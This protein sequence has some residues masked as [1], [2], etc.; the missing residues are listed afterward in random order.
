MPMTLLTPVPL[1]IVVDNVINARPLEGLL[2][3]VL[4]QALEQSPG[5]MLVTAIGLLV[6]V[7]LIQQIE[8]FGSW[9]L[10]LYTGERMV[11]D[12][13]IRLFR[14]A[15]RLSLQYHDQA[16][17]SDTLYRI[18][19]D[20]PAMQYLIVQGLIPAITS[21]L[22]VVAILCVTAYIDLWLAFVAITIVPVLLG[23]TELYRRRVRLGWATVKE[24]ES[25]AMSVV[26]EVLGAV[27]VVKAFGQEKREEYRFSTHANR[28]LWTQIGVVL[29]EARFGI[30]VAV[31]VACGTG[32]V[33]YIGARHV[34]AGLLSLGDLLV[35]MA[36]L[37]ML[38][39]PLETLS[40]KAASLQAS[41][42]SA[43]RAYRLFD[44]Q[45]EVPETTTPQPLKRAR[46]HIEF[47]DVSYAY[48][49]RQPVLHNLT[50]QVT[51]GTS[52]G[53]AGPTG[54]GKTT[55]IGLLFRF[56]DPTEGHIKLDGTDIRDFRLTDLRNQFAIV[57]QEPVLFAA[58][59]AENIAYG[60]PEASPEEI[61]AAAV[62]ANAHEFIEQLPEGYQ[63]VV[64][65][66]GAGISGGQRQRISLARAFLKDAPILVLDEP[67]SS[68]D[69]LSESLI[70]EAMRRLMQGR[71][72]LM[73]SHRSTTLEASDLR[74]QLEHGCIVSL[75]RRD[76]HAI[77]T[78]NEPLRPTR[79]TQ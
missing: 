62:A 65:Q 21:V 70:M 59:I 50:F 54:A 12:F 72:T 45:E 25:S 46:G 74:L 55:L 22:T 77:S 44:E 2:A 27:R 43:E 68:V 28:S 51:P 19:H 1:K 49:H 11:L 23:L 64:G 42:A 18:E 56:F 4:P 9:I 5:M 73:I 35:V 63:T 33:L 52:V 7:T 16:G 58:T 78:S 41:L 39:K 53:I 69:V 20:A 26:Q 60:R 67:T 14:H 57:L 38:Y 24:Q 8:G 75:A 66:R 32:A 79:E 37:S 31:T 13:R 48:P 29:T 30:L 47:V 6:L 36:Y 34:Q 15:Q 10:Q 17:A 76:Q 3:F 40:R 71:T 61:I